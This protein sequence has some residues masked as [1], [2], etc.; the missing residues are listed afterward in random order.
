L[1]TYYN[2]QNGIEMNGAGTSGNTLDGIL[3]KNGASGDLLTASTGCLSRIEDNGTN[4]VEVDSDASENT[5]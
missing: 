2:Y 4:G 3:F 5:I 1:P